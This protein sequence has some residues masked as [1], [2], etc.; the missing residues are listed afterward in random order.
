VQ[1]TL[2]DHFHVFFLQQVLY[3]AILESSDVDG[4]SAVAV[5]SYCWSLLESLQQED[6]VHHMLHYLLALPGDAAASRPTTSS[7]AQRPKSSHTML[8]LERARQNQTTL[9]PSFFSLVDLIL[10]S[11]SSSNAGA[12]TSALRLVSLLLQHHHHY[13]IGSLVRVLPTK[14]S[15]AKRT[16]GVLRQETSQLI[17][18]AERLGGSS[19]LNNTYANSLQDALAIIESHVCSQDHQSLKPLHGEDPDDGE[20]SSRIARPAVYKHR[21]RL[22]DPLM[23]ALLSLLDQ[24]FIND[25]ETNLA[26]T[27]VLANLS[28]CPYVRL[29][30]WLAAEP[31]VTRVIREAQSVQNSQF[32]GSELYLVGDEDDAEMQRVRAYLKACEEPEATSRNQPSLIMILHKLEKDLE[33]ATKQTVGFK[34]LVA[35][36]RR[37]FEGAA[38]ME[39]DTAKASPALSRRAFTPGSIRSPRKQ[40]SP[41]KLA[42][43]P[44]NNGSVRGI[45]EMMGLPPIYGLFAGK[46]KRQSSSG[47]LRSK[48]SQS[49]LKSKSSSSTVS[50][51][52]LSL[53]YSPRLPPVPSGTVRSPSPLRSPPVMPDAEFNVFDRSVTFS[54]DDS[55]TAYE[56]LN[57]DLPKATLSRV[58]TNVVI[59]QDFILELSAIM[60]VRAGL[61]DDDVTFC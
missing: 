12:L 38:E 5:L 20:K 26:L 30:S 33:R 56:D 59:L 57:G 28:S 16:P 2:I 19:S 32:D 6:L 46:P 8:M 7:G 17:D 42:G 4:G 43:S 14:E 22:D 50:A 49:T 18:L 9:N 36:R 24:F 55:N 11:L 3:P 37:A 25:V 41:T 23:L 58:L 1:A 47:T 34:Q 44:T 35:S 45:A 29:E 48:A 51:A 40:S 13:A 21:L 53:A 27:E 39:E 31:S 10:A 54:E 52:P 60:Q 15:S 61:F